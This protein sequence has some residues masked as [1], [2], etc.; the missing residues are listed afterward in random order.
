MPEG[1]LLR[2]SHRP[3]LRRGRLGPRGRRP[4]RRAW[5]HPRATPAPRPTTPRTTRACCATSPDARVRAGAGYRC[6][7]AVAAPGKVFLELEETCR[8]RILEA[9]RGEGGFGYDPYFLFPEWDLTFAEVDRDRKAEVSHRG[10]ALRRLH[11]ELPAIFS[12]VEN[13]RND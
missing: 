11:E 10:R 1:A 13:A 7:I 9:P 12:I 8:G 6:A 3:H 5:I 2:R 4:R